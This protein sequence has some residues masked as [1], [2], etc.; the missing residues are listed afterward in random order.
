M[1]PY[2]IAGA[3]EFAGFLRC[4]ACLHNE[5]ARALDQVPGPESPSVITRLERDARLRSASARAD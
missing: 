3:A 4:I 2:D 1:F 5:P